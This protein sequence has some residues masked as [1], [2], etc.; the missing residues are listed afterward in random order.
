MR[1][2]FKEQN[3]QLQIYNSD[4]K[5]VNA[6][7]LK[8]INY[9]KFIHRSDCEPHKYILPTPNECM[10]KSASPR[11]EKCKVDPWP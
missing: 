3:L 2:L 4:K 7:F 9:W 8:G 11:D 6:L 1:N 10:S 5:K